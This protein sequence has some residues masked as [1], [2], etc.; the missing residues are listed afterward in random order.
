MMY[1]GEYMDELDPEL[2][3]EENA[4]DEFGEEEKDAS[5]E[6]EEEEYE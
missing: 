1:D 3:T 6:A 4:P 5:G 2:R